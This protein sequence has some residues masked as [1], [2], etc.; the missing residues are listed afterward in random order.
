[1]QQYL[2]DV[3]KEPVKVFGVVPL[4]GAE[5]T[6][7]LKG[8]GYG[9]PYLVELG[10]KGETR[11]VVLETVRREGFGHDHFADRAAVL[12]MQAFRRLTSCLGTCVPLTWARSRV[13]VRT[14]SLW[15]IVVSFL[16]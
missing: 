6:G 5:G 4:R 11:R 10:V 12:L 2:S 1:M 7:E 13:T 8:F 14:L 3:Y 16:L 9:V 15:G